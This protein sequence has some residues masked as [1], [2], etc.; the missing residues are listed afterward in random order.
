MPITKAVQA[1]ALA[2]VEEGYKK[3]EAYY[4][5]TFNRPTVLFNLRGKTGGTANH[6]TNTLKF[7]PV[8]LMENEEHYI[9]STI[10]HEVAHLIDAVVNPD[11]YCRSLEALRRRGYRGRQLHGADFKFVMEVVLEAAD[12]ARCHTYSITNLKNGR[13]PASK[14]EWK[15]NNCDATMEFGVKRH[16]RMLNAGA[17]GAYRPRNTGCKWT[18]TYSYVGVVGQVPV[19]IAAQAPKPTKPSIPARSSNKDIARAVYGT[20][21]GRGNFITQCIENGIKK[22]TAGTY[23]QNFKSGA[24]T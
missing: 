6:G 11:N 16:K 7:H 20:T 21:V 13:A 10:P 5:R 8:F 12:S 22:T 9:E 2:K 15:C 18:H 23:Y 1:R 14:H 17:R 4:S 19:Q 24:W 3:A